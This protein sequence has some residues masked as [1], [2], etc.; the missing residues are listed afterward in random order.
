MT[1][2]K[3]AAL[4]GRPTSFGSFFLEQGVPNKIVILLGIRHGPTFCSDAGLCLP[5]ICAH[6]TYDRYRP[7]PPQDRLAPSH[8]TLSCGSPRAATCLSLSAAVGCPMR[9]IKLSAAI[10]ATENKPCPIRPARLT[11]SF[12]ICCLLTYEPGIPRP[13]GSPDH[14]SREVS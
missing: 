8:T 3:I 14:V 6:R 5:K 12:S 13:C 2:L 4:F 9:T 7:R 10:S 11:F 1:C